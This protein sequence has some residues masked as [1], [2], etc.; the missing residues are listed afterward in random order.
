MPISITLMLAIL[1]VLRVLCFAIAV[2]FLLLA[3]RAQFDVNVALS[4][5]QASLG[6]AAFLVTG[7][8]AGMM[9]GALAKRTG[10]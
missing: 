5:F 9:R 7:V 2:L 3:I 10:R 1:T 8:A 6:G 4:W